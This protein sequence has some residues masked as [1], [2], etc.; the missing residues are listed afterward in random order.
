VSGKTVTLVS[1]G[2][3]SI[4]ADQAGNANYSAAPQ[5]TQSFAV[6]L[7]PQTIS[8]G[9]IAS[10]SRRDSPVIPL[11]ATASSGLPVVFS[12]LSGPCAVVGSNLITLRTGSCVIAANQLGNTRY[13][14]ADTVTQTAVITDVMQAAA[15]GCGS[16]G[17][18]SGL[19]FFGLAFGA[20]VLWR[21]R[22]RGQP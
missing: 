20:V 12:L 17:S 21:R 6:S 19:A 8:F 4:S 22:S 15:G 9:A 7:A 11:V 10:F 16:T 13:G 5:V 3:C 14:R 2:T 18:P 1:A